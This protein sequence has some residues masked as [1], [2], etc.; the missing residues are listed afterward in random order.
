MTFRQPTVSIIEDNPDLLD[1]LM[2]FL[3]HRGYSVWG[4]GSA[5]QFWKKLHRHSADIVL[6]DLGLPGEDGFS[7]VD[8]L[9]DLGDTGLII[10]TARGHQQDKLRGLNLGADLYL[11]KPVN[12]AELVSAINSLWQRMLERSP[13]NPAPAVREPAGQWQ[14]IESRHT[15]IAPEGQQ[16]T[17]SAQEYRLLST[18]G[19]S[20]GEVFTKEALLH[21]IYQHDDPPDT[22][23]IDVILSRLRKKAKDQNISLP[24]RSIF[25]K[26]LVFVGDVKESSAN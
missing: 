24:I 9:R 14:L 23:R 1:E 15:L 6:V 26:G 8:Y 10:V 18:M 17:L 13:D 12:F 20:P 5:E 25:G 3:Q 11:I 16:L 4:A 2:F 19:R 21:L 7:V 22:H